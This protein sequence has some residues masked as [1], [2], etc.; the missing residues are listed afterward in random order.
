MPLL[1]Y[2]AIVD[3]II[4]LHEAPGERL[5]DDRAVSLP[6]LTVSVRDMIDALKRVAGGRRLGE[7]TVTPDPFIEAICAT[8]PRDNR[9]DKALALGLPREETLDEIVAYY[10]EDYLDA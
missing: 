4:A 2:R 3:G 10:I 6:S 7:I 5:G 9:F 8:W 1:G